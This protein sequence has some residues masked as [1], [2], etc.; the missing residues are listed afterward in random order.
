MTADDLV[1]IPGG[2]FAMGSDDVYP[3][4]RPVHRVAV[5]GFW[6]DRHLVTTADFARFV[7]QTGHVTVAERRPDPADYPGVDPALL[8]PGSLVFTPPPHPVG[9]HDPRAWWSYVPGAS[10]RHPEGPGSTVDGRED[11]PVVHVACEDAEAYARWAGE[12]LPTEA[13]WGLA[14]R[15]G[16]EGAVYPWGDEFAPGGRTMANTWQGRFPWQD[17]GSDGYSRTSP[18]GAF[19]ANGY[20]LHDA[21]GDV[22]EWTSDLYRPRHPEEVASACCVPRNPRVDAADQPWVPGLPDAAVPRRVVKGGSH[23]CAPDYCLRYRPA[24][25]QGEAVDTSTGHLGFRCVVRAGERAPAD[26]AGAP[27]G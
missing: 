4:E 16:L 26:T 21:A 2:T 22:W 17:L 3:E 9:L 19:P 15:G 8:V 10:W 12:D 5:D 13:E 24:A 25:R 27:P 20:G 23:L 6:M 14:A 1:W 7:A 18:V 11:H